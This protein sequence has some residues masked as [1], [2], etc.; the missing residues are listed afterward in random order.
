[1]IRKIKNALIE[2]ILAFTPSRSHLEAMMRLDFKIGD[3]RTNF[4]QL[5]FSNLAAWPLFVLAFVLYFDPNR[6]SWSLQKLLLSRQVSAFFLLDGRPQNMILFFLVFFFI[7]WI[8]RVE[9]LLIGII[10]YFLLKSDLHLHLALAA[11]LAIIFSKN[12]Y[13]W[14]FHTDLRSRSH[15]IWKVISGLQLFGSFLGGLFSLYLLQVFYFKGYFSES[16]SANRFETLIL[17]LFIIYF[18]PFILSLGW[19][20]FYFK[21]KFNPTEFPIHYSTANWIL[22]FKMR[23]YFKK[24]LLDQTLKYLEIH[25]K[26]LEDLAAIKDLSPVSIPFKIGEI[27]KTEISL[28]KMAS[29]RLTI[30]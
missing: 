25:Q 12:C 20:H 19:G 2:V 5:C 24:K 28:L 3:E 18:L 15:H 6:F 30:D 13:L 21:K 7:Q 16:I 8:L 14:W 1:M 17:F 4:M 26:N 10:F 23:P 29:S 22:R 27:L 11:I 9:F